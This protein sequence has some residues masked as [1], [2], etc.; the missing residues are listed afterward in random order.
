[1]HIFSAQRYKVGRS[2]FSKFLSICFVLLL[3]L[4]VANKLSPN[5]VQ[6]QG[7]APSPTSFPVTTTQWVFDEEV[8][9]VGKNADRARQLLWW[10]WTHPGISSAPVIAQLWAISRNIVYIFIVLVIVAFGLGIILSKR[11]GTLG[12][13]FSGISPP[14][15]GANIPSVFLKI[16]VIL[17]YVT[18][19]YVI[20]LGFIQLSEITMQFIR[21]LAGGDLFNVFFAG[22]GNIEA[23]YTTFYGYRD[24]NPLNKEMVQTSLFIIRITSLT[25]N[26]MSLILILRN[27]ILWLLLILSPF[28]ALLMPFVFIRNTGW[29]WIGVFF[30]WL[31]YGPLMILFVVIL[32]N[33]WVAGIPYPFDF[34]RVNKP[35]GQ[36]YKTSIN[37]LYG[38][39]AQTLSPG[40]SANYV[41]TYA[42]YVIALVMLWA[43]MLVPWLLLRIFR[44]YCCNLL[45]SS[46]ATLSSI[47]DRLRQYPPPSPPPS[48][49][50]PTTTAGIAVELPFRSRIEEKIREVSRIKIE[51]IKEI[52][53]TNTVEIARSMDLSVSKL[54]DVSRLEMNA[55]KREDVAKRLQSIA[56]PERVSSSVDRERY[57]TIKSELQTRAIAGDRIAQ[58]MLVA[59]E[60][61]K[62]VLAQHVVST[63]A[64]QAVAVPSAVGVYAPTISSMVST[65]TTLNQVISKPT[66]ISN[67]SE[68]VNMSQ[69]QVREVLQTA[70]NL[71]TT[72]ITTIQTLNE[73]AAK[74]GVSKEK[75]QEIVSSA[76]ST[77]V[78][79]APAPTVVSQVAI[80]VG[81]TETKVKE[82]LQIIPTNV[83][84][85]ATAVEKAAQKVGVSEQKVKEIV[86]AA[87]PSKPVPTAVTVEDYEEVKKMWLS[88]YREAP[89]PETETIKDRTH[90]VDAEEKKMTNILNLL[91]SPDVVLKQKG[92]EQVAEILPFMLLGGFTDAEISAYI[93]AKLEAAK[94]VQSE[95]EMRQKVKEEVE[96]KL[97]EEEEETLV[98]VK[99]EDKKEKEA[100]LKGEKKMTLPEEKTPEK[101]EK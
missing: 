33:I 10:I 87:A 49:L 13:I 79:A 98:E 1:M 45:A 56:S 18:F 16:G 72:G 36:V 75:V 77:T 12:T 60:K 32:V 29:I 4:I 39:P 14:L 99:G 15:Y 94:Q 26:M 40:N 31:L 74:V 37:I 92:L 7:I 50:T 20:V 73:T 93:K 51:D 27:I 34:S 22:S 48:P 6:A 30:Q 58:A 42:E 17:V 25:Y 90:W 62:E 24:T 8:T 59:S 83:T 52:S 66:Q 96:K 84:P 63:S 3:F 69:Q 85:S 53:K 57:S 82:V 68:Q 28:L 78:S 35:E 9:Q 91:G 80:K 89:V 44:D 55:L 67:I 88:H 2:F 100:S 101:I 11:R 95:L 64:R 97:K 54:S 21:N 19:S 61:D 65:T 76:Q 38:G 81:V 46:N 70:I 43:S 47:F 5:Q 23:N 41:D 86:S 71:S